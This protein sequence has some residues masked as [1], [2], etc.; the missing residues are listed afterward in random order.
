M[1]WGITVFNNMTINWQCIH[2]FRDSEH[3]G[4]AK[5][6]VSNVVTFI[7]PESNLVEH[8]V[9]GHISRLSLSYITTDR[10]TRSLPICLQ[11]DSLTS[12][13]SKIWAK[14][15]RVQEISPLLF[16]G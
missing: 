1:V 4:L 7:S 12:W 8:F 9:L 13:I 10:S 16:D 3:L 15:N 11:R 14:W 5:Y 2:T 6:S